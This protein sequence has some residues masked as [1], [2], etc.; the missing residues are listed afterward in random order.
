MS[1]LKFIKDIYWTPTL[2]CKMRPSVNPCW[3][4]GLILFASCSLSEFV[5]AETET[6]LHLSEKE[7][8]EVGLKVW[9]NECGGSV[10]GL[11]SWNVGEEF[12]SLGIGHFI[13]YP[14]G[15]KGPF[16]ERFPDVLAYL[17]KRGVKLP[18]WLNPEMGCPWKS[19][20]EFLAEQKGTKLSEL[21]EMLA[22]TIGLQTDYLVKRLEQALPKMLEK[23]PQDSRDK[24]KKQFERMLAAGSSGVFALIDYV[25]FKGEG[26]AETERYKGEGWGMLQVLA[27]MDEN[28]EPVRAFADSAISR[29]SLRVSN[30]P[31]QRH[32]ERWLPGWKNRV[33]AYVK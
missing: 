9:R 13:W 32:E 30:S 25:N 20:E 1:F 16:I 33:N 12:P 26:I 5:L 4:A 24:I 6:K 3:L 14:Q 2:N 8:A 28:G 17:Q 18:A 27:S 10:E 15:Y 19:R 31:P 29:L 21:R 22:G 23:A 11:T 7:A